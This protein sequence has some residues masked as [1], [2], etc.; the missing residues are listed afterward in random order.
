MELVGCGSYAGGDSSS[1]H[2]QACCKGSHPGCLGRREP[3][4]GGQ[5]VSCRLSTTQQPTVYKGEH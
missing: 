2:A 4:I 5:R 3:P 1:L